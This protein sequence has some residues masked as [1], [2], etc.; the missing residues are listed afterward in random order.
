M[1]KAIERWK[2][3]L[4]RVTL[5]LPPSARNIEDTFRATQAYIL[6]N[7]DGPS[8]Q[9][10]SRTYERSWIRDG[11]ITST[12]LL[13]TGHT[14]K[15]RAFLEWYAG[16]QFPDGKVPCVVDRRGP[17]PVPEH[18]STGEFIYALLTYY[19][20]TRDME[21]LKTHLPQ[22]IKGVDYLESL[23]NQ[24]TT[25]R[26]QQGSP[27]E[28]AC[29]GL[30]P[31]SISHEG[32]SAKPMHSYWDNFFTVKGLAD[33]AEIARVLGR[34]DLEE[35]FS[36]L[37]RAHH[38]ALYR[39]FNLA[40]QH[41]GIDYLPGCAELGDFDATSTAIGVFPCDQLASLPQPALDRTFDRY[42]DFFEQR[43]TGALSWDGYTPY[44]LRIVGTFV[45]LGQP[46]RAHALLDFFMQDQTPPGWRQWAEVVYRD[47]RTPRFIG[48]MPHTWVGSAFLNSIRTM[49][50]YEDGDQLV[51]LAG[52]TPDW[53]ADDG[54]ALGNFPTIY[55]RLDLRARMTGA[56]LNVEIEGDAQPPGG[57]RLILPFAARPSRVLLD[58]AAVE[59][60]PDRALHLPAGTRR[61]EVTWQ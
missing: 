20:H 18:D 39:S 34:S 56:T 52:V 11:A 5:T 25:E 9:P 23:R 60:P 33:A 31:E 44:E 54:V 32:Y 30:V 42:F 29:Y 59:P 41:H 55:G 8:I 22:V 51:L 43:R 6:I 35:R 4:N 10:G 14:E 17:D 2:R 1:H 37:H 26:Y 38:V 12:A 53:L 45:R 3:E 15:V 58:D 21:F 61:V 28:R 47:H 27:I 40:M 13:A 36:A 49:F 19:R 48:D 46:Q 16:H 7:G 24:R 50:V 57:S